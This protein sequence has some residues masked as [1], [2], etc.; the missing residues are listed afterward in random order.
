M[1]D[2]STTVASKIFAAWC[3]LMARYSNTSDVVVG[4]AADGRS[5]LVEDMDQMNGPTLAALPFRG[6]IVDSE[7]FISEYVTHIQELTTSM[8]PFEQTG[9]QNIR[10]MCPDV[11]GCCDLR[12]ILVVQTGD[13]GLSEAPLDLE[14]H[15]PHAPDVH[16]Q[17]LNL[18]CIYSQGSVNYIAHY[19]GHCVGK[20]EVH[21]LL[22]QLNHIIQQIF[23]APQS[24][25][26]HDMEMITGADVSQI[27][28][29]KKDLP[30][31][32]DTF[33][34]SLITEKARATPQAPAVCSW[35]GQ[36]TYGELN[37]VTD[38]L[39]HV[40]FRDYGVGPE[41]VVPLLFEKSIYALVS[42][43]AVQKAGGA[44]VSLDLSAPD[45]HLQIILR[46]T[47]AKLI[48]CSVPEAG[49]LTDETLTILAV[50]AVFL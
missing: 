31:A 12:G 26:V 46:A 4:V 44:F 35:D 13:F 24:F 50:D 38:R 9:L 3:I 37:D 8:I 1:I 27:R 32:L 18:S 39:A 47:S 16:L 23:V 6:Q 22:T 34:H 10:R 7:I 5:A 29:W 17:A 49:K 19:D 25:R 43:V 48:L 42:M 41:V 20:D 15:P 45:A 2:R 21:R 14:M 33:M 30:A 11:S 40:L 36:L 28:E